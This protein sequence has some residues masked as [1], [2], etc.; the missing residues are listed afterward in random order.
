MKKFTF[1]LFLLFLVVLKTNVAFDHRTK[2]FLP[3]V[4]RNSAVVQIIAGVG[5]PVDLEL[6]AV[7]MGF[8]FKS[9][10]ILPMNATDFWAVFSDPFD[11][12]TH[13]ITTFNKRSIHENIDDSASTGY[14]S[15]QHE[16]YERHQI[17]A[18]VVESGTES[19]SI[20]SSDDINNYASTRWLV[21]KG[22]AEIAENNGM[23]GKPCVLRSICESAHTSFDHSNGILGELFHVVMTPSST[24]D[25]ITKY[26]DNEYLY[27]EKIG[28]EGVPCE[29]IFN[30]CKMSILDQFTGIYSTKPNAL[31]A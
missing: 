16:Q 30:E 26:E 8:V 29:H 12:S 28:K 23:P 22:L 5:L 14:D 7:T 21:Y 11:V 4:R 20:D 31:F 13:P 17:E 19:N 25:P 15:E 10:F 24:I 3:F 27:A 2:R 9:G 6:E 18:E 1:H